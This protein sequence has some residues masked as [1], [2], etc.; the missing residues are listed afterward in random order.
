MTVIGRTTPKAH[1]TEAIE[2][3][4]VQETP[5]PEEKTKKSKKDDAK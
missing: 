5:A 3:Q 4:N 2:Q 1:E